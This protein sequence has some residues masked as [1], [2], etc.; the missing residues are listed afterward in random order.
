MAAQVLFL[1][2]Q[3]LKQRSVLQ[4][5]VDMKI[6][7]PTII[8]VQEFYILPILGTSLYNE[9]KSQIAAGTVSNANKN[10]IDNYI[11]NTMIWYMQVELPLAM[12]YKY[13]NKAVGV[14][15]VYRTLQT[16]TMSDGKYITPLYKER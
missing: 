12:N 7:T 1:S 9:L 16:S 13:F 10:L 4:D 3:T 15:N 11:T 14:Q 5:N 8:E 6:V 2:E